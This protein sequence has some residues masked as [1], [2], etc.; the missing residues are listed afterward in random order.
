MEGKDGGNTGAEDYGKGSIFCPCGTKAKDE[1][2]GD[3]A[4]SNEIKKGS[5]FFGHILMHF[6]RDIAS[7]VEGGLDLAHFKTSVGGV[8]CLHDNGGD[9]IGKESQGETD[10]ENGFLIQK[11]A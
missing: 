1:K 2:S 11:K 6:G 10:R 5:G 7:L 4:E 3:G 8:S 9:E